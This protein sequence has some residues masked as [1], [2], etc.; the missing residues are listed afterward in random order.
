MTGR[1]IDFCPTAW[2]A[3]Q[4]VRP[5]ENGLAIRHALEQIAS[6]SALVRAELPAVR[7]QV[8]EEQLPR[9]AEVWGLPVDGFDG[10]QWLIVWREQPYVVEIGHIGAAPAGP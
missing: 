2:R 4:S 6:E 8:V 1:L 7:Y 9:S 3:Y 10:T 5:T